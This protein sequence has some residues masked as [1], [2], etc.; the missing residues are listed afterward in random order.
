M[1]ALRLDRLLSS[2][3]GG[4][5][6]EVRAL[7]RAGR[8][9]VDGLCV[10][11]PGEKVDPESQTV[12]VDGRPVRYS[13]HVYL[14]M[15]KP[16]GVV[17]A[18]RDPRA[19]TV[20]DL[21]PP[22]LRRPGLFPAGRLDKDTEGML[23]ITDDGAFAHEILSP[24]RHVEKVYLA[25]LDAPVSEADAAAFAAGLTLE[26]GLRCLPARLW[27]GG[28]CQ[29]Y[30]ALREGKFHQVRRMFAARGRQVLRLVRVRM[31]ALALPD[32]LLPGQARELTENERALINMHNPD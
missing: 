9:C 27:A 14:V 21:L 16:C 32:E 30:A 3:G 26:D 4:T 24:R 5:R 23:L 31:G 6:S 13:A 12:A 29:A 10:R 17:S 15:N 28:G 2:Q 25:E 7:L 11:D 22:D 1:P 18:S 20:L 8:V 19:K